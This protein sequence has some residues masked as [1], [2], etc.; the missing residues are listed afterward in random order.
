MLWTYFDTRRSL[1]RQPHQRILLELTQLGKLSD[2]SN[3]TKSF[4]SHCI[5]FSALWTPCQTIPEYLIH[6]LE[7]D[8]FQD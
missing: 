2:L 6:E 7:I 8:D 4:E 5:Q 1:I 3:L